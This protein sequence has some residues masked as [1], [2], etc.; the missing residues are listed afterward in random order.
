M[1]LTQGLD[2]VTT[3][4]AANLSYV[5][6]GGTPVTRDGSTTEASDRALGLDAAATQAGQDLDALQL[7]G[8]ESPTAGFAD[9]RGFDPRRGAAAASMDGSGV[10]GLQLGLHHDADLAAGFG[11]AGAMDGQW[12]LSGTGRGAPLPPGLG[13]GLP[14]PAVDPMAD[15][16]PPSIP[17]ADGLGP[18]FGGSAGDS[19]LPGLGIPGMGGGPSAQDQSMMST[20]Q[21][22]NQSA[23]GGLMNTNGVSGATGVAVGIDSSGK[24]AASHWVTGTIPGERSSTTFY[25]SGSINTDGEVSMHGSATTTQSNGDSSTVSGDFKP[26]DLTG[27]GAGKTG[28]DGKDAPGQ[29]DARDTPGYDELIKREG[30]KLETATSTS[31]D[32]PP[33]PR[34]EETTS[35]GGSAGDTDAEETTPPA[36]S[37]GGNDTSMKDIDQVYG[38]MD[39]LTAQMLSRR[40]HVTEFETVSRPSDVD[41]QTEADFEG[42]PEPLNGLIGPKED[43]LP[44]PTEAQ[45]AALRKAGDPL[46]DPYVNPNPLDDGPEEGPAGPRPPSGL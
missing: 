14:G 43:P 33:P 15:L 10:A 38:G 40:S 16:G 5:R 31:T 8:G 21:Q 39:P 1:K 28:K 13:A 9:A 27:E 26:S 46:A 23:A 44:R 32:A 25:G 12:G 19:A 30:E 22:L 29:R 17:T 41:H 45:L 37:Q 6:E 18:T 35:D 20:I 3:A 42:Q 34:T 7:T 2:T 36:P 11:V 24:P 4:P